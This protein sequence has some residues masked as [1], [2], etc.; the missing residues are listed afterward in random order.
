MA[1]F[2]DFKLIGLA[3]PFAL[4]FW[5]WLRS[6]NDRTLGPPAPTASDAQI[7]QMVRLG[8]KIQAIKAIR[9]KY[10]YDLK[11]AKQHFDAIQAR[12]KGIRR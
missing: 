3:L 4:A 8:Q 9:G 2:N 6:H 10:G 5:R 7:E 11:Q 12:Q 1:D